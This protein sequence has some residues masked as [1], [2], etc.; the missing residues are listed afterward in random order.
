MNTIWQL[1]LKNKHNYLSETH[2][3][4]RLITTVHKT[5]LSFTTLLTTFPICYYINTTIPHIILY[6]HIS[7]KSLWLLLL[8]LLWQL[9]N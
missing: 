9:P 1:D 6:T 5:Q 7:Q 8:L 4:H 3:E 2:V